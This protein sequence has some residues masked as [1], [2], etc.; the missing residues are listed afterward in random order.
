MGNAK[1]TELVVDLLE[2]GVTSPRFTEN[3]AYKVTNNRYEEFPGELTQPGVFMMEKFGQE[4]RKEF[5]EQKQFLP[6]DF[7]PENFYHK[8]YKDQPSTMSAYATMLGAYPQSVSWIQFQSM[9][10]GSIDNPFTRDEE[11]DMRKSLGLSD[12][13]SELSNREMTIWSETDGRTFFNDPLNNC[14][15][16][17]RDMDK[18][19]DAT[20]EKYTDNRCNK[21]T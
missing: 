9:G 7:K 20:N 19:L 5:I 14:P 17:H 13:P 21:Y 3:P 4:L 12:N 8:S 18:N 1:K 16:M 10:K 11:A 2:H 6:N 15:Q